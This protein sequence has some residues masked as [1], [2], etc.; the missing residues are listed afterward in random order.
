MQL[1]QQRLLY[2]DHAK[3]RAF[4][5]LCR[6]DLDEPTGCTARI[7]SLE[8]LFPALI[9][10]VRQDWDQQRTE[11][12]QAATAAQAEK[13]Q[14]C[15]GDGPV[16]SGCGGALPSS[17]EF[18]I[19]CAWAMSVTSKMAVQVE[20]LQQG[21]ATAAKATGLSYVLFSSLVPPTYHTPLL[22]MSVDVARS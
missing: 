18:L 11:M 13:E 16:W 22:C 2:R 20:V 19:P 8:S 9:P 10:P 21:L 12:Q 17:P 5:A 3:G 6:P 1:E 7:H 15:N 14:V 4:I